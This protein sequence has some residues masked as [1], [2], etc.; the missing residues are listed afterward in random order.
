[1]TEN[2]RKVLRDW[3][4]GLDGADYDEA[5]KG[6]ALHRLISDLLNADADKDGWHRNTGT[7]PVADDV[8]VE[9]QYRYGETFI[10]V[11]DGLCWDLNLSGATISHWRLANAESKPTEYPVG[12]LLE[13]SDDGET[14]WPG[15]LHDFDPDGELPYQTGSGVWWPRAQV[16][17]DWSKLDSE[18]QCAIVYDSGV[19]F[20][21]IGEPIITVGRT[22]GWGT[23]IWI[24]ERP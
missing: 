5:F 24:E 16:P 18:W 4:D 23:V 7:Q 12:M 21:N 22:N 20:P 19:V 14:W 1:M 11:A 8:Q 6:R 15:R 9:V 17:I 13:F 2:E 10:D 3:I